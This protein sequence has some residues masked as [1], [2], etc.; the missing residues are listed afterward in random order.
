MRKIPRA[1][2][3]G[4]RSVPAR[5]DRAKRVN[6]L[7]SRPGRLSVWN[8]PNGVAAEPPRGPETTPGP[9]RQAWARNHHTGGDTQPQRPGLPANEKFSTNVSTP[10]RAVG[11]G[12]WQT[13]AI[14]SI[15]ANPQLRPLPSATFGWGHPGPPDLSTT[16]RSWIGHDNW[17]PPP[18]HGLRSAIDSHFQRRNLPGDR[19]GGLGRRLPTSAVG[20]DRE[21]A[22][23]PPGAPLGSW[24]RPSPSSVSP[25]HP[26]G[27]SFPNGPL[28][29]PTSAENIKLEFPNDAMRILRS[30]PTTLLHVPPNACPSSFASS[31]NL[32]NEPCGS[33]PPL[34][35]RKRQDPRSAT[36]Q[37]AFVGPTAADGKS[38]WVVTG[39]LRLLHAS[40]ERPFGTAAPPHPSEARVGGLNWPSL[41]CAR[42]IR[43][44]AD[45]QH[46]A[47]SEE[48]GTAGST[49][50][51][52]RTRA[53]SPPT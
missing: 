29:L 25:A 20:R 41:A 46:G 53:G 39:R 17:R 19:L 27:T 51:S 10:Q 31:S 24:T 52:I 48:R 18:C 36:W 38:Q 30:P 21:R 14:A 26:R 22:P 40:P 47:T 15:P 49:W 45:L 9:T 42:P 5:P 34:R 32:P 37:I 1:R 6:L 50:V 12:A 13:A 28:P 2:A 43:K 3:G 11:L 23:I 16:T 35:T 4:R 7:T 44:P 33:P 8:D